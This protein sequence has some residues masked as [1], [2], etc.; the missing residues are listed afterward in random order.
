MAEAVKTEQTVP[1]GEMGGA[2]DGNSGRR[3]LAI[4]LKVRGQTVGALG[5][6]KPAQESTWSEQEVEVLELLVQQLGDTLVGAQL[7]AA[8]QDNAA[9]EQLVGELASRMRQT[10]DVESVLRTTVEE[11]R[12]VL[13]LPEVSVRLRMPSRQLS[14]QC[15]A[16]PRA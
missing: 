12:Q 16:K 2:A 1:A 13:D 14:R 5:F 15:Q 10:L 9:R 6:R 3:M 4:P 7:Y 8:A 11:V